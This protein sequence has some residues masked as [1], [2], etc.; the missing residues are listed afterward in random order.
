MLRAYVRSG[1]HGGAALGNVP[2]LELKG[3]QD[4]R[5]PFVEPARRFTRTRSRLALENLTI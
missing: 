3:R 2:S 4:P 5:H 1:R